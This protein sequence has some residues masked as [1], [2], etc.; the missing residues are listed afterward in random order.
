L[1]EQPTI[2]PVVN[3]YFDKVFVLNLA[4][5]TERKFTMQKKL[6]SLGIEVEYVQA[7]NGNTLENK[8]EYQ[9]YLQTETG[10][11]DS[12]PL[13]I[14]YQRKLIDSAG[15]WGCLKTFQKVLK[16]AQ[17]EGYERILCFEDDVLF[18]KDFENRFEKAVQIIPSDWKLLYLGA[19]QYVWRIPEGL[20]YPGFLKKRINSPF[21][22]PNVTDGAFSIGIHCSVFDLLLSEIDK[23]NC[24]FDSGGLRSVNSKFPKKCFV[25][26][27][28][29]L[30]AD[31]S[32]SDIRAGQK[33][34][35]LA[36]KLRWSLSEYDFSFQKEQVS[37]IMPAFNAEQTIEKS[38]RSILM[39]SYRNLEL[40]VVDDASTDQTADIVRKIAEKDFR[41]RILVLKKNKGVGCARNVGLQAACGSIIAFQDADDISLRNRIEKQLTPIYEKGVLFTVCRILRSRCS[42]EELDIFNQKETLHLVKKRRKRDWLRRYPYSD[43]MVYGLVTTIFR[44]DVFERYGLYENLRFGEDLEFLERL[45]HFMKGQP[46]NEKYNAHSLLNYGES[47]EGVFEK[48]D[49]L[50][51]LCPKMTE[52]NLTEQFR[53]KSKEKIQSEKQF[54]EKYR[55]ADLKDFPKLKPGVY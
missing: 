20:H 2:V 9:E 21:Y 1:S 42:P 10:A 32:K 33:Q 36:K 13:E 31:V 17:L 47:I 11:P 51:Y 22:Y 27:P 24:P 53:N 43:Q 12:H 3:Q 39:Q 14:A 19:S 15:A 5:R 44:R 48:T 34:S 40:I 38:V 55:E 7:I 54:R 50:L 28:N 25:L 29:L 49:E 8:T 23:M 18:H 41:L 16:K 37:V 35:E 6:G 46:F 52:G 26:M 45:F 4:H 30:I